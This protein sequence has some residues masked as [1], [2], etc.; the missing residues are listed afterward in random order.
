MTHQDILRD[1]PLAVELIKAEEGFRATPYKCTSGKTTI[2]YGTNA[3]AHGL[4]VSGQTWTRAQA[5]DALLDELEII[6]AELDRR[7][8]SWRNL[9]DIR[10][11]VIL[12]SVYQLGIYGAAQF[13]D[14]IAAICRHDFNA[15]AVCLLRS[16][17]ARQTP[18]RV[19]R[20]AEAIRTGKLPEVVNGVK[21]F[22]STADGELDQTPEQSPAPVL[23]VEGQGMADTQGPLVLPP[24]RDAAPAS[25]LTGFRLSKKLCVV[26]AGAAVL[27][28]NE[29][30]HFGLTPQDTADMVKL[31][32][33]YLLGQAGVDA[34]KPFAAAIIKAGAK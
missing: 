27:L 13:H 16:K 19:K 25:S 30:L 29:P 14:T 11:A 12:S 23:P 1:F 10:T 20:N 6:I 21:I 34:F 22:A 28:L 7:W 4:D 17:W 9:D 15:A 31:L 24:L 18:A 8:P 26:I 3:D 5:E 2:G 32:A 33:S